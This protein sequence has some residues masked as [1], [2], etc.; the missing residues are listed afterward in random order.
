MKLEKTETAR[1][2]D[3]NMTNARNRTPKFLLIL[4][5]MIG[6]LLATPASATE[7]TF[8]AN[9]VTS[10]D[11]MPQNYGDNVSATT[12]GNGHSYLEGNGWTPNVELSYSASSGGEIQYD[13]DVAKFDDP[14]SAGGD[15]LVY[16]HAGPGL[17]RGYQFIHA[18][19][20]G[21]HW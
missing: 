12:D 21:Y 2:E 10:G 8:E 1:K 15:V 4:P 13:S 14:A 19:R 7:L 17:W 3:A 18:V 16:L 6:L 9:G 20:H 11:P 5:A